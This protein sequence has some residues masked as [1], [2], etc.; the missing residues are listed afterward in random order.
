MQPT[1]TDRKR[2]RCDYRLEAVMSRD[3]R[4]ACCR[5]RVV[6]L[7]AAARNADRA[8]DLAL[9]VLDRQPAREGDEAAVRVLDVVERPAR[10]RKLADVAR[11]HVEIAGRPR[12]PHRDVDREI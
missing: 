2:S 11:R 8:D 4:Y 3:L 12:F 10:L 9:A 7:D 6:V 1:I 5:D